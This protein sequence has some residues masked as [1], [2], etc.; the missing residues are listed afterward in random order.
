MFDET[1]NDERV[2]IVTKCSLDIK[3]TKYDCI[4]ENIST[5]GASVEI[6]GSDQNS[7]HIGD[8]G[9]LHVLLL[10]VVQYFFKVVRIDSK[11]VG[12]QFVGH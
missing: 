8:M 4:V 2:K 10:S 1:R 5:V 3:G 11:G 9:T 6:N 7:I 12:L